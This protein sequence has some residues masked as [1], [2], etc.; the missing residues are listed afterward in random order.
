MGDAAVAGEL[1]EISRVLGGL[2]S[3]I[4]TLIN[5]T[6][7]LFT[8][9]DTLNESH[10]EQRGALKLL[11][12]QVAEIKQDLPNIETVCLTTA[13]AAHEK[14][15]AV[16]KRMDAVE[17]KGKGAMVGLTLAGTASGGI[18]AWI[19][20]LLSHAPPTPPPHP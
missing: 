3:K 15:G 13:K 11:A 9:F 20:G 8:K 18:V 19:I 14:A 6:G 10:I 17:N 1:N 12:N 5:H 16:E 7:T 2:E 4:G